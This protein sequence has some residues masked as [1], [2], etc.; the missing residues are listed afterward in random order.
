MIS[1]YWKSQNQNRFSIILIAI[2]SVVLILLVENLQITKEQP[3]YKDKLTAAKLADR[4]IRRIQD[5]NRK[6]RRT[7]ALEFDPA[8]T[9]LIGLNLSDVTSNVGY[10]QAKRTSINPNFAAII[11]QLLKK[12]N[13]KEGDIVAVGVSGSFPA[14]NIATYSALQT[15]KLKPII[16]S[17]ATSSQWGANHNDFLWVDMEDL[18]YRE[19]F[20]RFKSS[21][22]T[23]GGVED[24]ALGMTERSKNL[25]RAGIDRSNIPLLEVQSF[26]D[27]IDQRMNIYNKTSNDVKAYINIGGGS[28][29]VGTSIGKKIFKPGLITRIPEGGLGVDSVI[30]RFLQ[31]EIPVIN[32]TMVE[33][34]AK[35]YGLPLA[36]TTIPKPGEGRIFSKN[37]YNPY[38]I[39]IS[40][41]ILIGALYKFRMKEIRD[42]EL[43]L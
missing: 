5:E 2:L 38:L 14:M 39:F 40:L 18:L 17:S 34:L 33:T 10:L 24:R 9:G 21:V 35:R 25:L 43:I 19:S 4:A 37:E 13:L 31:E 6:E 29:S 1:L 11:V 42:N 3:Y 30:L 27:G 36:P 8:K 20:F 12:A 15:L 26:T 23:L 28:L 16:I 41:G 22:A 32:I 7:A